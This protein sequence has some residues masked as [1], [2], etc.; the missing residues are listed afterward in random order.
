MST[1][2][3]LSKPE[4]AV[5]FTARRS[6]L[7][8]VRASKYDVYGPNGQRQGVTAGET[9]AF[10][11][12]L[13]KVPMSGQMKLEDGRKAE[14]AEILE[15]LKEHS[16]HGNLDEGFIE[17]KQAA[18]PVSAEERDAVVQ[19]A[20]ALDIASLQKMKAAE[21]AGWN[22]P[23]LIETI[24]KALVGAAEA[25]EQVAKEMAEQEAAV[26]KAKAAEKPQA[27]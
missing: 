19:S 24:E 17:I 3:V 1:A 20:I 15:W 21:A 23:D 18:P 4:K 8:L 11:D 2:T 27:K 13:L 26:L 10:R 14:A 16:L 22:R 9:V 12:G 5:T 25:R 6:E 7:R